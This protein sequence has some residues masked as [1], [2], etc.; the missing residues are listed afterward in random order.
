[1]RLVFMGTPDFAIP[2]L[3]ALIRAGH[4]LVLV[5]T[6]PD[7]PKGR[8]GK[9][10][11]PPVKEWALRHGFPCLQPTRLKDPAFLAT[12]REAKP[13]AIVVVAYGKI[14][15]PEVLNLSP[16]GCI[17]LHASL[18]PKYRGAAPIQHALIAGERETGVTTMLM[19]E[20]MDTGDILLQESLVVGE[21]ENFGS[22]HDRL[23]QLGAEL[24]C[25]T[26][27]LWEEG[28]IKP[29]PQDHSQATYA[30]PLRSEDE[31]IRWEEPAEK[32]KNLVRALDPVPGART[33]WQGKVLKIWRARALTGPFGGVP[34]EVLALDP[35][36]I[37]VRAGRGALLV[38]EL[39]L[40]GG[41]RLKASEFL[42]GHPNLQPGTVLGS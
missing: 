28:K 25:R 31:I 20:G 26:L 41:K 19:D 14:L 1:M 42:R 32:I 34:G 10:T 4:K 36:G 37:V 40:A 18:L 23:A 13:E 7:R 38:L 9:L 15:P 30:P 29:Q 8:G 24:L 22:L 3:E 12:L 21:E 2:S 16:R 35:E 6:Q 33:F 17:N 27:S 39:Q 5:V 11:P